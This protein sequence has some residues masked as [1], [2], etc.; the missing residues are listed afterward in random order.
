MK[1][2]ALE[3]LICVLLLLFTCPLLASPLLAPG[4]RLAIVQPGEPAF[5]QP[6][7]VNKQGEIA[8]P[9]VG[10][11]AVGGKTLGQA[12]ELIRTAL[13]PVYNNLSQLTV[14]L[15]EK[16]LL[17]SVMGYVKKPG[18]YD[19]APDGNVQ[20]ALD[21]AGGL[22]PG[23]QLNNMQVR[24]G[25]TVSSFDY[26]RYLD[27]GDASVL[28]PLQSLDVVF[29]PASP[30]IGNVQ[31]DFDAATLAAGGDG[32]T[33]K[34]IKVFGEV[35]SPGRLQFQER[36]LYRGSADAGRWGDP[37]C[38]GGADPGDQW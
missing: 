1:R 37:L 12:D 22:V 5:D 38:R 30:L 15:L 26:K 16:R 25:S 34:A 9:E 35:N 10:N 2:G 13:K 21:A 29:V 4:D 7:Q 36:Q 33:G 8:L 32:D 31:I 20:M 27:T 3:G 28:P 23:A 6:F 18:S 11:V 17:I 14:T 19:L 24:R